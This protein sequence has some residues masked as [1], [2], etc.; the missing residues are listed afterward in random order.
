M[1]QFNLKCIQTGIRVISEEIVIKPE[2]RG[3]PV[4]LPEAELTGR[5]ISGKPRALIILKM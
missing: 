4:N 3:Y 5:F 2:V 1:P